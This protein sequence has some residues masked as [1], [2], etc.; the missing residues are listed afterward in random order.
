[1][2]LNIVLR[3][4]SLLTCAP[5]YFKSNWQDTSHFPGFQKGP[6]MA[7]PANKKNPLDHHQMQLPLVTLVRQSARE[8]IIPG[9]CIAER[10]I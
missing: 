1:M 2:V 8:F 5:E 7:T 3:W 4:H 6:M 9:R 10:M